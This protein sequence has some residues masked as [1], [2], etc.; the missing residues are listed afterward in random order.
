MLQISLF[1]HR[2]MAMMAMGSNFWPDVVQNVTKI[3]CTISGN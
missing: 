3:M 2:A 1:R